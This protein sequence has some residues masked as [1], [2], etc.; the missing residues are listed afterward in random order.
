MNGMDGKGAG[1]DEARRTR[2]LVPFVFA[3][4]LVMPAIGQGVP[5][6]EGAGR[7]E[8]PETSDA[9]LRAIAAPYLSEEERAEKRVFHGLWTEEDLKSPRLRAKAALM[10][11]VLD[12]ASLSDPSADAE[13][14]AEAAMRRGEPERTVGLLDGREGARA[15]RLRAEA[16]E[17]LGRVDEAR[18][19]VEPVVKAM[20]AAR[21]DEAEALVEGVRALG[22]KARLEGR[23]GGDYQNMMDL[24]LRAQQELDRLYWPARLAQA[25]LLY[26]KD[27]NKDANAAAVET[28]TLNPA[29]GRAWRIIGEMAVDGFAFD[30]AEAVAHALDNLVRRLDPDSGRTSHL[31]DLAMARAWMRQNDPLLAQELVRRV[32]TRYPTM[33]EALALEAA[34]E[35]LLFEYDAANELLSNLD[36]L[37]PNTPIG[38]FEVGR[39]LS[40][41]RQYD[42]AAEYLGM[43]AARQP[44]WAAPAIE[45]GLLEMQAGRDTQALTALTRAAKLDPFNTRANNSLTLVEAMS[46]YETIE[47][48]HFIVR[49]PGGALRVMAEE[50]IGPLE[51]IHRIVAGAIRHEPKR[52]TTIELL[53]DHQTFAVRITGVTGI[54]TIA[55]ATGPVIAMEVPKEGK[56]HEGE[57]DWIRVVRHEYTHTITL[58]RTNN[59]IPHWFTEAAAVHLENTPRDYNTCRMLVAALLGEGGM[60]LFDMREINIAF[61]RPRPRSNDRAQAYAQGHWMYQFIVRRWDES[62]PL[63]LMD[64]YSVGIAENQAMQEV[65]GVSQEAFLEEFRAW[66]R[67]DAATWGMLPAKSLVQLLVEETMD[68]PV[69][70]PRAREELQAFAFGAACTLAGLEGGRR[71]RVPMLEPEGE[72]VDRLLARAPDH[73]DALELKIEEEL[74]ARE[75]DADEAMIPLLEK[76]AAI[77]PVDPMPH[78]HL[79]RLHLAGQTPEAAIPHLEYL[80]AREQKSAAYAIELARRYAALSEFGK[81]R[82]KAERATQ[83]APFDP[84]HREI[85]AAIAI[86]AGDL[87]A[88]E[89]HIAA[90]TEIEPQHELHRERLKR[91]RE[92][93]GE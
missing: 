53:P 61:V 40:E 35:A 41:S 50:M 73:P 89:R 87:A 49:H 45:L 11:G 47:S 7:L 56:R 9:V 5:R 32:L 51:E 10:A 6:H 70:G 28:L 75:G 71:Y 39:A 91:V 59:R 79:A 58:S 78:R 14:R 68:D 20:L 13:D 93:R 55:A 85:A 44:N 36:T 15:A 23:P 57:Y 19:A 3:V 90:L 66:A 69:A 92:M 31:G 17:S 84:G 26:E 48:E 25:E 1:R 30:K 21:V 43:A 82:A 27:N 65:L 24:L 62:A 12:D 72:V 2:W 63:R 64:L 8:A 37:S 46:K 54:H 80:D 52:K 18:A 29:C 60:N 88:A 34:T 74:K 33:R 81:A 42:K 86:Q 83:I 22:V 67:S 16:F 4:L 76:Y 38:Y 77:R